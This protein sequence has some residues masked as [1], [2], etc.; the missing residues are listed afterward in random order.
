[1]NVYR[2]REVSNPVRISTTGIEQ[3]D[4]K[5]LTNQL[6]QILSMVVPG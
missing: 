5:T 4:R 2:R 1:M 3:Y 6:A